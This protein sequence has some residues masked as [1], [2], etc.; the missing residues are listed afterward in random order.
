[1]IQ[2][3]HLLTHRLNSQIYSTMFPGG[4]QSSKSRKQRSL[5]MQNDHCLFSIPGHTHIARRRPFHH[6]PESQSVHCYNTIRRLRSHRPS[7]KRSP[8]AS[9][10]NFR[11]HPA[12]T[13]FR[14]RS[15]GRSDM[16]SPSRMR[17]VGVRSGK[18]RS[19]G[20]VP[21]R[22]RAFPLKKPLSRNTL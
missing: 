10:R 22:T 15:C 7:S 9:S 14:C 8:P 16:P 3:V 1:M 6:P 13:P 11:R 17:I 5:F 20:F 21:G 4:C 19:T 18:L 12:Q 2:A